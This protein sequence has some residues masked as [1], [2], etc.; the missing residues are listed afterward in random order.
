VTGI[1]LAGAFLTA[2]LLT[3]AVRD[4][5][6]APT[7]RRQVRAAVLGEETFRGLPVLERWDRLLRRTRVG[8][9]LERELA[10]AAVRQRPVVVLGGGLV[11]TL[12]STLLIWRFVAPVLAVL[13]LGAGVLAVR[14]YLKRERI[15]RLEAFIVQMPEL[16]R[17]L[18]NS[19]NA[20]LS[21]R[22]AIATASDELGE[23][24]RS[25]MARVAT[26][27]GFGAG[28]DEALTELGDR[29]PS[30]EVALLTATLVVSARSGGSMVTAL[31]DI[32]DTLEARKETRREIRTIL[33]QALATGY[34]IIGMGG[35]IL[36]VLNVLYDGVVAE[37]TREPVGQVA[38]GLAG[39]LYLLGVIAIRRIARF[40]A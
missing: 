38:L 19:A 27:V 24:A 1:A 4:L 2:V 20:G 32:A 22:S 3:Y 5:A 6:S 8:R 26:R 16:A 29:L 30:R 39:G 9:R 28:L 31:R 25:E 35:L 37:M 33:S 21:I 18:A 10:L 14:A 12:V 17:V 7:V 34:T 11:V 36:L 23:P 40:D 15:R 13:G